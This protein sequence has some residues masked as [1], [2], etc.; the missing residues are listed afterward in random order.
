MRAQEEKVDR[1]E[2]IECARKLAAEALTA[3]R[4][5][6]PSEALRACDQ[7]LSL[8]ERLEPSEA[9]ADVLRWK[10]SI[11]RDAGD[12]ARAQDLF[13][14]SLATADAISY[15]AGRAHALNCFGTMAQCR[16]DLQQAATWYG[17]AREL[18]ITLKSKRLLGLIVQNLGIIAM[19]DQRPDEALTHFKQAQDAF[20]EEGDMPS[21]LR[22]LSHLGDLYTRDARYDLA[23]VTLHRA[24]HLAARLGDCA[25]EGVVEENRAR[26]LL[27]TDRLDDAQEAA[28]RALGVAAQR[29]DR[30]R[31]A[32]ALYTIACV[33]RKRG[34]NATEVITTLNRAHTLAQ[35]GVDEEL[36]GEI[37]RE[38]A[39]PGAG[40]QAVEET[41]ASTLAFPAHMFGGRAP[42]P[43]AA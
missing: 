25:A 40:S 21:L 13:A 8:L 26:Y 9:L 28:T 2:L 19:L 4:G 42:S 14:R 43:P 36:K 32:A 7:A 1:D 39:Q 41:P 6:D 3:G 20:E 5:G 15:T 17:A 30:T 27:A 34:A 23:S 10:G 29:G 38:M 22:V 31:Q 11:L 12:H 24:L 16:G 37:L 18:A 35:T 33:M